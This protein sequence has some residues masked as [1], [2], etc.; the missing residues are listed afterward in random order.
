[1]QPLSPQFQ[2]RDRQGATGPRSAF[3]FAAALLPCFIFLELLG[4]ANRPA[5]AA[6]RPTVIVVQGAPGTDTYGA[7]F[8]KSADNWADAAKKAGAD[9]TL[10]GRDP[11]PADSSDDKDRLKKA[12]DD[13]AKDPANPLWLVLIGHGTSDGHDAKFNLRGADVSDTELALW[14]KPLARPLAVIDCSEASS[15]FLTRLSAPNR[16]IITATRA[17]SEV[18]YCRFG[19]YFSEAIADPAADL[20]KDGQVSLLEAFLSAAARTT[21]FYKREGRLATEHSLLDDNGDKMGISA[22]WF[23]GIRP[24]HA[25]Q[26]GAPL[27]GAHARQWSL[28]LSPEEEA[29]PADLRAQRDALELDLEALHNRK[30][31]LS[32]ENYYTQLDPLLLQIAHIYAQ[33]PAAQPP[34]NGPTP[35]DNAAPVK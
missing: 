31:F 20:D 25:A 17:S 30:Q 33:E 7:D 11:S 32:E 23:D 15:P 14:L 22:D 13:A 19:L 9:F 5:R 27:D 2:S 3:R 6:D 21:D 18:N 8:T 4:F 24:S 1:M 28:V 16:V 34:K 29:M 26:N 10:I 12:L 35:A